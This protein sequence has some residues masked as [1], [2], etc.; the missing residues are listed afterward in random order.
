MCSKM[1]SLVRNLLSTAKYLRTFNVPSITNVNKSPL[2][3]IQQISYIKQFSNYANPTPHEVVDS[4]ESEENKKVARGIVNL[5]Y[6]L[7]ELRKCL[8]L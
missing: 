4:N 8:K 2:P 1:A 7:I 6:M 5:S 3:S